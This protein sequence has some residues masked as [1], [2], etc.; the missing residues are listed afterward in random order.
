MQHEA[1]QP[2]IIN[3]IPVRPQFRNKIGH[4]V[5]KDPNTGKLFT[6]K[7][8]T[9]CGGK[10]AWAQYNRMFRGRTFT[11][12][13]NADGEGVHYAEG[14]RWDDSIRE[15]VDVPKP[16][17]YLCVKKVSRWTYET[18]TLNVSFW[19]PTLFIWDE[20]SIVLPKPLYQSVL[21]DLPLRCLE[22]YSGN[23]ECACHSVPQILQILER[24]GSVTYQVKFSKMCK[25][26]LIWH[27]T[28]CCLVCSGYYSQS[29]LVG[30]EDFCPLCHEDHSL[31]VCVA[32]IGGCGHS[33]HVNC[34]EISRIHK[35]VCPICRSQYPP[36]ID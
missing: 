28:P 20:D 5:F 23:K 34:I 26:C 13:L 6:V 11:I 4:L 22:C 17:S 32:V 27:T 2:T 24:L 29:S 12:F 21:K 25:K 1:Q 30:I 35:N 31:D 7:G 33:F 14:I 9:V 36:L 10:G 15:W 8:L 18:V 19:N 16:E 3:R